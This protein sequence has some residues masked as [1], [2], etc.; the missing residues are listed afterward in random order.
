[1][2]R[3]SLVAVLTFLALPNPSPALSKKKTITGPATFA[4]ASPRPVEEDENPWWTGTKL[5]LD[6]T[7]Q[8]DPDAE[9]AQGRTEVFVLE[10]GRAEE[11]L[12]REVELWMWLS[13]RE[14]RSCM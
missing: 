6:K 14:G 7:L 12:Q 10:H 2:T 13:V 8:Q 5:D 1:V 4:H 9:E 11:G 3:R